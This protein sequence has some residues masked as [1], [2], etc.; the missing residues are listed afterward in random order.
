[1]SLLCLFIEVLKIDHPQSMESALSLLVLACVVQILCA[2][3]AEELGWVV[4]TPLILWY[5]SKPV[6]ILG[7]TVFEA[8]V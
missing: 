7:K 1:M 6:S 5:C 2:M 4:I 8:G 3:G